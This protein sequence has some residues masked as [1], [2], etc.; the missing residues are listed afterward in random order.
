MYDILFLEVVN[1]PVSVGDNIRTARKSAGLTQKQLADKLNLSL[2]SV[3]R[4]E[5]GERKL[6]I[7]M[8][9]RI[10]DALDVS[11]GYLLDNV[12]MY[13][14]EGGY[15]PWDFEATPPP[16]QIRV[17]IEDSPYLKELREK[18]EGED[19]TPGDIVRY[20]EYLNETIKGFRL[21]ADALGHINESLDKLPP[22]IR[23]EVLKHIAG[24]KNNPP[25]GEE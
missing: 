6:K 12:V 9:Q 7:D 1:V 22:D 10:A 5:S 18:A 14:G 16:S 3:R 23:K 13:R 25:P 11:A 4:Y 15:S 21:L 17:E 24:E 2:M 20:E 19:A 8:I